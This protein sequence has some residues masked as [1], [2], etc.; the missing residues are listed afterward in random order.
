MKCELC[1]KD[2]RVLNPTDKGDACLECVKEQ[3]LKIKYGRVFKN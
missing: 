2:A 3:K 1:S